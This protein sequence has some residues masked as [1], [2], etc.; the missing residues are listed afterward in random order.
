MWKKLDSSVKIILVVW[1][2]ALHLVFAGLVYLY[3][4]VTGGLGL[5]SYSETPTP[6]ELTEVAER[7]AGA[8]LPNDSV[9]P[10]IIGSE[11]I[12]DPC[13]PRDTFGVQGVIPLSS[14]FPAD[15]PTYEGVL[16]NSYGLYPPDEIPEDTLSGSAHLVVRGIFDPD[17]TQCAGHPLLFPAWVFGDDVATPSVAVSSITTDDLTFHHWTCFA[18]F[19]VHEYLVGGGPR[20]LSVQLPTS[21]V[22]YDTA[23]TPSFE[24]FGEELES[25]GTQVEDSVEGI[26]WV[27]WLGPSYNVMVESLAAY[28]LWDLQKDDDETVRVVSPDAVYYRDSGLTGSALDRLQ[29]P[30]AV[31]RRD[32]KAAH[33]TRIG[34]TSGRVGVDTDT[35]ML[36]T[37]ALKLPDYYEEIGAYDNPIAT[38]APPPTS[39]YPPTGLYVTRWTNPIPEVDLEWYAPVSS[40]VTHYKIV[41]IDSLGNEKVIAEA[42]PG[43]FTE[44]TDRDLPVAGVEYTYTVIAVN[45]HG[46]SPPSAGETVRNG[47]PNPPTDLYVSLQPGNEADLEWYAPASSHVT[48]YRVERKQGNGAWVTL[49]DNIPSEHLETTDFGLVSGQ[50]YTYRVIALG[51][52][53]DSAPS[54]PYVLRVP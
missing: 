4:D 25:L 41:R 21:G 27:A 46:E 11:T 26:E 8:P 3:F 14:V 23:D 7:G 29:A 20:K 10:C 32:I 30:L 24:S 17:R 49:Q 37:D 28:A 1:V 43:E 18:E 36:V 52:W 16:F 22:P 31:F 42:L 47:P 51:E 5:G 45:D 2:V 53:A 44:T 33:A 34:R 15:P 9:R 54:T 48:G 38:P 50:A 39:P 13:E 35:P 40:T 19:S 6:I 12:I